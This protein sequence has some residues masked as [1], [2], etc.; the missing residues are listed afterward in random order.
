MW[1][2][3]SAKP[4]ATIRATFVIPVTWC[5]DWTPK[6]LAAIEPRHYTLIFR[7]LSGAFALEL[8]RA[9]N[10]ILFVGYWLWLEA[11]AESLNLH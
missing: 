11:F 10:F 5:A 4:V 6:G 3:G 1:D 2:G 7:G 8:T 9:G